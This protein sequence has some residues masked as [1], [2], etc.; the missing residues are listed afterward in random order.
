MR[1]TVESVDGISLPAV[2]APGTRDVIVFSVR[3]V[4]G[5]GADVYVFGASVSEDAED[6]EDSEEDE[7]PVSR[8]CCWAAL[9]SAADSLANGPDVNAQPAQASMTTGLR[10]AVSARGRGSSR[11]AH[12]S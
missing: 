11:T 6:P 1:R 5:T 9:G 8:V 2:F 7:L 12:F 3:L 4:H 10:R